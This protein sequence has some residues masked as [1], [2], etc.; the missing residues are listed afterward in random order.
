[1]S[2][3]P[4]HGTIQ[5]HQQRLKRLDASIRALDTGLQVALD[6]RR[7][8]ALRRTVAMLVGMPTASAGIVLV[9]FLFH[10]WQGM[11]LWYGVM[12]LAVS[13]MAI[14]PATHSIETHHGELQERLFE[15]I[16]KRQQLSEELAALNERHA[17][18]RAR[19]VRR[20]VEVREEAA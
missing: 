19:Q 8:Q 5:R 7:R 3:S 13:A 15:L 14:R 20:P 1:M 12:S 9:S 2:G 6:I 10:H 16:T 11:G 17:Q 18:V 4:I